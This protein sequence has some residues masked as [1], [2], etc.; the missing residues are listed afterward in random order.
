LNTAPRSRAARL[1][2]ARL[3]KLSGDRLAAVLE[4]RALVEMHPSYAR[5]VRNLGLDLA[6]IGDR[7]GAI[8]M[9]ERAIELA[10]HA[11]NRAR[12]EEIIAEL[13]TPR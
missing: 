4:L 13:K 8:A 9:L 10:P 3:L 11:N 6:G 2:Y 1:N 7:R 5:A 12:T